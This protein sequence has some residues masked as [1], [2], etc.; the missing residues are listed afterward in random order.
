MSVVYKARQLGFNRVVALKTSRLQADDREIARFRIEAEAVAGL[1]HPHIVRVYDF[2][3][4]GGAPYFSMEFIDGG[5]LAERLKRGPLSPETAAQL[6]EL[7]ARAMHYAHR[8]GVVH[9]DLKPAN[10][11]LARGGDGPSPLEFVPKVADFG[12]AKRLDA[13]DDLTVTDAVM[14]TASY[15][16]PE[17]AEGKNREVGPAADVYGL[18]A[19]LYEALTARPPFRSATRELTLLQVQCDEPSRP[20]QL[21][22]GVPEDLEA[23]CLKCLEKEPAKR[24]ATA[25]AL[26]EDLR[27][28]LAGEGTEVRPLSEWEWQVRWGR[29]AG[30]ELLELVGWSALGLVYR[31][32]QLSLDR[33]VLLKTISP[34]ARTDPARMARFRQEAEAAAKLTHP[35]IVQVYDSGERDGQSFLA[36]EFVEGGTL[37]DRTSELPLPPR[38]AAELVAALAGAVH[39]AHQKGIVH[40][41]LRPFNV[42]LTADGIPKVR[43]FGLMRLLADGRPGGSARAP[44][45]AFSNYL[46][47]EQAAGAGEVGPAADIYALGAVLYERLTGRPPF[48]ADTV[49]ETLERIR[50]EEP[51]PPTRLRPD[52]PQRLDAVCLKC[53]QKDPAQRYP[54]AAALAADL[55]RFLD[56]E[57]PRTDEFVLLPGYELLEEL[58][59]GG[60]GVVYRARQ[61]R[62]DR[63]VAVKVFRTDLARALAASRAAARLSHPNLIQVY[64]CGERNGLLYVA[65]ELVDGDSLSRRLAAGLPPAAEAARWV[66]ALARALHYAHRQGVVHRNLKPSVVLLTAGGEPKVGSFELARLLPPQ[67]P[68]SEADGVIVGTPQY[69]PPEQALG[70]PAAVGPAA[71]VYGLGAVLYELLTGRPP[72][73]GAQPVELLKDVSAQEPTPPRQLRPDTPARLEAVCLRCLRKDPSDRY[74]SA[75]AL[76]DDLRGF[77]S[78]ARRGPGLWARLLRW[79]RG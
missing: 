78:S 26:A 54:D 17:Q 67:A 47:P 66:E 23:V 75:E 12:L 7:L 16:A 59:R 48:L 51:A 62:L 58:G 60:T 13:S 4:F 42:Q 10:V 73:T 71:D 41:D 64:D 36:M 33:P 8:Q 69:M 32:Q 19:V 65:E 15:M 39:C 31:A 35:N 50:R 61:L 77:L 68:L 63:L 57:Q 52:A 5:S 6:V 9:R 37:A 53:L 46:A 28:F 2:G 79:A 55:R 44:A 11:L 18:G 70:R 25:E 34:Q 29:R 49:R 45:G 20:T 40:G 1:D 30:Y 14:G 76:A 24:Y 22:A 27:R 74:P 3:E 72:F 43:G 21:R 56:A 38:R